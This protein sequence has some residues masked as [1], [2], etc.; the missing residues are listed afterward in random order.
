MAARNGWWPTIG[1]VAVVKLMRRRGGLRARL[2][3]FFALQLALVGSATLIGIYITQL[4]VEDLLTRQALALEAAHYWQLRAS[5]PGQPL[6][7][8]ANMRGYL[9]ELGSAA[10]GI[11]KLPAALRDQEP[12]FRRIEM[13]GAARLVHV[14]DQGD[15]RLYLVFEAGQVSDLAFYFGTVPLSIVLLMIYGSLFIAYRWSQGALSP[16]VRLARQ[17]EA[18][19]LKHTGGEQLNLA[20]LR[21]GSDAEVVTLIDALEH[22]ADR[23]TVAVE[24]ERTFTR[25]AGH[26]L[27]T[28]LAVFKGGLDLLEMAANQPSRERA[29]VARM[30]RTADRMESLLE[31][32]MLLARDAIPAAGDQP[33]SLRLVV[34]EEIRAVREAARQRGNRLQLEADQDVWV[35]APAPVVRIVVGNLLQN[36]VNYTR[37]GDVQVSLFEDGVRFRDTG[38]GMSREELASMFEPFYRAEASRGDGKGHGL[39]LA[40]VRRLSHRFGWTLNAHS[41][42]GHGTTVELRFHS[43]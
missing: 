42:P 41:Q 16:I 19:D 18:I 38:I 14:S 11:G 3:R 30:R 12:G 20:D 36:A 5:N 22:F 31:A 33:T 43:E 1:S 37:N 25:D 29:T 35:L 32:L 8:T 27:R 34:E 10:T 28:P 24:R 6:P 4:V 40:I 13:D 26:E 23:V 39:G 21:L 2:G 17:L 7:N 9:A 15:A